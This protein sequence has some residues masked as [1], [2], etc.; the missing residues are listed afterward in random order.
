[1]TAVNSTTIDL[2]LAD[3]DVERIRLEKQLHTSQVEIVNL[4]Y[5]VFL[6]G[7]SIA[8]PIS[9]QEQH[10]RLDAVRLVIRQIKTRRPTSG[11]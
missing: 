8:S 1:M 11:T 2:I 6:S 9:L 10:Q 4:F 5:G 3:T 7:G